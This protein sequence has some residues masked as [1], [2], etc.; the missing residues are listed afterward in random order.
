MESITHAFALGFLGSFSIVKGLQW[1]SKKIVDK[2]IPNFDSKALPCLEKICSVAMFSAPMM[3]SIIDPEG[4]NEILTNHPV[5]SSG[6][7]GVY[8]GSLAGALHDLNKR[9]LDY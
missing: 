1:T 3:Y 9:S 8:L 5:Y 4:A 7:S 6:M 2:V